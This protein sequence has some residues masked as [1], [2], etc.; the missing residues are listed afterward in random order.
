LFLVTT[1]GIGLLISTAANT[2]Q[3]AMLLT[4]FTLLPSIFL[5][6]FLF[7]L[8][9]MPGVLQA[10]SLVIPQRYFVIVARGI[11]LKGVGADVLLPEIFALSVFALLVM[12][13]TAVRFRKQLD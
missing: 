10:I 2:Q 7:P 13:A 3:E 9:A 4:M 1:L 11:I 5:S 12:V 6:G 8:A